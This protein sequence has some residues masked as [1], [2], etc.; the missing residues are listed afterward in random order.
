MSHFFK[1]GDILK[2]K[3]R[4]SYGDVRVK[5][6][7]VDIFGSFYIFQIIRHYDPVYLG[8]FENQTSSWVEEK[9]EKEIILA[10]NNL[11]SNLNA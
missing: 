2:F 9:L 11:W 3:P 4:Y 1:V 5:I 8:R 10:Y 7:R 6:T